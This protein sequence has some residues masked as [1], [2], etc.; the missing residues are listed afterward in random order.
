MN[1]EPSLPKLSIDDLI[2]IGES[3]YLQNGEALEYLEEKRDFWYNL[4]MFWIAITSITAILSLGFA[5]GGAAAAMKALSIAT[6]FDRLIVI[7]KLLLDAFKDEITIIP[8]VKTDA[9]KIELFVKTKD[10]RLFAFES[11]SS[12]TSQIKWREDRQDFFINSRTSKGKP[13]SKK[14][15]ELNSV[16]ASLN[17]AVLALKRDKNEIMGKTNTE[18]KRPVIKAIILT[19]KTGVDPKNDAT[20]FVDFGK[21]KKE[22]CK[23]LRVATDTVILLVNQEDLVDFL[24]PREKNL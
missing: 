7:V 14:W 12:G 23:V 8:K 24:M 9:G 2:Q 18:K 11:R 13:R 4:S 5:S 17:Q 20:L 22:D 10:G 19:G 3:G 15:G 21:L 6:S 16:S 1:I